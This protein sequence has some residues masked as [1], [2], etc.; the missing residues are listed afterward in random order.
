L[1]SLSNTDDTI[2]LWDPAT[3]KEAARL[4]TPVTLAAFSRDGSVVIADDTRCKVWVPATGAVRDLPADT[5][6]EGV[7]SLAVHP[8]GR[9]FAAATPKQI[10][11]ID[12]QTGKRH[13]EL[14]LPAEQSPS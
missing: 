3:G 13:Q 5:L 6:P 7:S 2:R 12:T 14:K 11:I 8:N 9:S 4:N 10:W 1:A